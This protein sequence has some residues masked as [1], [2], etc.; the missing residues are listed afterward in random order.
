MLKWIPFSH[1][2]DIQFARIF[3]GSAWPFCSDRS[4]SDPAGLQPFTEKQQPRIK[5]NPA[6]AS[7]L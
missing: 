7:F 6:V 4:L 2:N 3:L 5:D 1:L